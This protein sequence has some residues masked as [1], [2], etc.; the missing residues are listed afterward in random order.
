MERRVSFFLQSFT[1]KYVG[2]RFGC[3]WE[4]A[5]QGHFASTDRMWKRARSSR[6]LIRSAS[7]SI[8]YGLGGVC[9]KFLHG[10]GERKG[11]RKGSV[12][13]YWESFSAFLEE[14]IAEFFPKA[15]DH[16]KLV[17][18]SFQLYA[19]TLLHSDDSLGN[20]GTLGRLNI[21]VGLGFTHR[22]LVALGSHCIILYL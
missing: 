1:K 5:L 4:S 13:I 14:I 21:S 9:E 3:S 7:N 6:G 19:W 18:P 8:L 20:T 2:W 11:M 16:E 10:N 22:T 12:G 15:M 17:P